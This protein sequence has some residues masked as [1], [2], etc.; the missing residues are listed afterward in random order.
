MVEAALRAYYKNNFEKIV[1]DRDLLMVRNLDDA[2]PDIEDVEYIGVPGRGGAYY[3]CFG[4][5]GSPFY[6]RIYTG[7]DSFELRPPYYVTVFSREVANSTGRTNR[8]IVNAPAPEYGPKIVDFV[9]IALTELG[10]PNLVS[11]KLLE[12]TMD[13]AKTPPVKSMCILL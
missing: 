4:Q 3:L 9:I 6:Y 2:F 12:K 5:K 1:R 13:K 10:D 11:N 7:G 8:D